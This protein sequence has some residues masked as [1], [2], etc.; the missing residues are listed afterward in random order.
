MCAANFT[1][2]AQLHRRATISAGAKTASPQA[3]QE[4]LGRS[5]GGGSLV[6]NWATSFFMQFASPWPSCLCFLAW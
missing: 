5:G 6:P 3:F 4:V 1:N 2:R